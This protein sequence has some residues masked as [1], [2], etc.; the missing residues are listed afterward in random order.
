LLA[1]YPPAA[2]RVRFNTD[3]RATGRAD[4]LEYASPRMSH[5]SLNGLASSS[6]KLC[7]INL[8]RVALSLIR[9]DMKG[10]TYQQN[11]SLWSGKSSIL[12]NELLFGSAQALVKYNPPRERRFL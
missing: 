6:V 3:R 10:N 2:R 11:C 4:P 1:R 9:S 7:H 5:L 8:A 12:M